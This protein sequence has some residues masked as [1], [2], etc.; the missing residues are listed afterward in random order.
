MTI[1]AIFYKVLGAV[2]IVM[3]VSCVAEKY[4]TVRGGTL[5]PARILRCEK[6]AAKTRGGWHYVV[7][8]RVGEGLLHRPT[9]DSF[10]FDH[11]HKTDSMVMVWFNPAHPETVERQSPEAE[12]LG[13]L[14]VAL[15]LA[16]MLL[17]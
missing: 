17:L 1:L 14:F 5:C 15:G 13:A 6:G 3:G 16:V 9:N 11:S 4:R 10:W 7:E 8:I 2:F 12:L